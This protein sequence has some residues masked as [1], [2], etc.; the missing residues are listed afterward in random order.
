MIKV[1]VN[2]GGVWSKD[3][4]K[5][6][7][8][9]TWLSLV[10]ILL[11]LL[12]YSMLKAQTTPV[13]GTVVDDAKLPLLGVVVA[14]KGTKRSTQTDAAGEFSI[15]AGENDILVFTA[16]NFQPFQ[17]SVKNKT[18][19]NVKLDPSDLTSETIQ[20]LYG[21][22]KAKTFSGA[23][24]TIK[25]DDINTVGSPSASNALAG[26]LLGL[27]SSQSISFG[28]DGSNFSLRNFSPVIIVDGQVR[29]IDQ[30]NTSEIAEISVL[31]DPASLA[32]FGM[33]SSDGIIVVK[34][35][36]G[37]AKKQTISFS[38]QGALQQPTYLPKYLDSYNYAVLSNE[39][40]RNDGSTEPYTQAD[41]DAYKNGTDPNGHPNVD[42]FKLALKPTYNF[43]RYNFNAT[44]GNASARYFVSL[45]N[46][47]Q[48]GM[49]NVG[50]Q[51][52]NT[53]NDYNRYAFRS[54]VDIDIDKNTS[55]GLRL[56]GK[57]EK[58]NSPGAGI[59]SIM[60]ALKS[61]PAN[62]YP[63][64]IPDTTLLGG[65]SLYKAN[66]YGLINKTGF[67]RE[68]RRIAFVDADLNRKLN[69]ITEGLS[70]TG[71]VHYTSYYSNTVF[72]SRSNFAVYQ[73]TVDPATANKTYQQFGTNANYSSSDSYDN[74]FSRRLSLDGGL[75][76]N[77]SFD[78]HGIDATVRYTWDQYDI[79][80][81]LTHAYK[82]V[83][84]RVSYDYNEK[85]FADVAFSYQGTEQYVKG[86]RYGFFPAMSVGYDLAKEDFLKTS[87]I[88]QLKFKV[89]GGLL[90]FD[91]ASNYAYQPYYTS[92]SNV[93]YFGNSGTALGGWNEAAIANP[94]ITWEKSK[95]FNAG[96]QA[97]MLDNKLGVTVEYFNK[98]RYDVL[99]A[100]GSSNTLLGLSYPDENLGKYR[101]EGIEL[102]SD[103][104]VRLGKVDLSLAANAQLFDNKVI[105]QDEVNR[106]YDYQYRT[107]QRVG[108][109][110]G[111]VALGL[112]QSQAEIATSPTQFGV[113]LQ[114]GDIKYKDLNGDKVI[115]DNDVTAI[116]KKSAPIY[117]SGSLGLKYQGFDFS[118]VVQ[119]V[120]NKDFFFT[121]SNAWEFQNNG[122]SS[123]T[124]Q[125]LHLNRWTPETA[126]TA[127]YPRLTYG[128]N[129]N[130]HR[131]STYWIKDGDYLR[132]KNV[133]LGYTLPSSASN[134]I[135]LS[136]L[137]VFVNAY[138]PLT[139][140]KLKDMDPEALFN[141]YPLYKS[142]TVGISA[143][144]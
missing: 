54:N 130:N 24:A 15:K 11:V 41:L 76:Y 75:S 44:G 56:A 105:F 42:W 94:N 118:A 8:C 53:N 67:N 124:V 37:S 127:T 88:N 49:F 136:N 32:P 48:G 1:Y 17:V 92:S 119:G 120:A 68:S 116:G 74:S 144:F 111:L 87:G 12:P 22:H 64:F 83:M 61:T 91:R 31:K 34:T 70:A 143:K 46:M 125:N 45:E 65:N 106:P 78:K 98:Y 30:I 112:F 73:L 20:F 33:R 107:G 19:F 108:Q 104:S 51:D 79:G 36:S 139:I 128:T 72:R 131:T 43:T 14:V 5:T 59:G 122:V 6:D 134:K 3:I 16:P 10:L 40:A 2:P 82:G 39:A 90:G 129:V 21:T 27:I 13:T 52:Y 55:V 110:F 85:L 140:T 47:N 23:V 35:K 132:V 77:H 126:A 66:I 113:A 97:R 138:N 100:P 117:Y 102:G 93:Y 57:F 109:P 18:R 95:V 141:F 25:G 60:S 135:H 133:E 50:S 121:G 99:Q 89:S 29:D 137:R 62:A 7:R 80:T 86:S 123:G 84:G 28:N 58:A 71:S 4:S 96:I 9:K 63:V 69:F 101:Y 142:Y 26:R 115:D 81:S 38:A 114:P 103:Y